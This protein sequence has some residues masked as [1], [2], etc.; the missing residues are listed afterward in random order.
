MGVRLRQSDGTRVASE[1]IHN[2][3]LGGIFVEMAQPLPFG[4]EVDVQLTLP[5]TSWPLR[6]TGFVVR[7]SM[8]SGHNDAERPGVGMR[9]MGVGLREMRLLAE[10]VEARLKT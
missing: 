4:S 2:V 3:S 9:L 8:S 1:R 10:F 7:A 6:C 5:Q